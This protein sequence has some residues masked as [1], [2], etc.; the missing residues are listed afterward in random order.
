MKIIIKDDK[1]IVFPSNKKKLHFILINK[2]QYILYVG[3]VDWNKID[4]SIFSYGNNS[5]E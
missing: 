3:F 4:V 2:L 5:V 1:L